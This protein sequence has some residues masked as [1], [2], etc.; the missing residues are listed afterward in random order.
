[1]RSHA[2]KDK[3]CSESCVTNSWFNFLFKGATKLRER[4]QPNEEPSKVDPETAKNVEQIK[5]VTG[6][7]VKVSGF[8]VSTLCTLTVELGRHLSPVIRT[9]GAKVGPRCI[10]SSFC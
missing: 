1:M 3:D 10:I 7:A 9:Q 6:A 4:L 8:I 2:L 5:E